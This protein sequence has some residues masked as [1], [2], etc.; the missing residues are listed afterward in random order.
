MDTHNQGDLVSDQISTMRKRS[1]LDTIKQGVNVSPDDTTFDNDI[2]MYLN[3]GFFL[4]SNLGV[5][6]SNQYTLESSKATWADYFQYIGRE[7]PAVSTYLTIHVRL[8][9]DPPSL[10]FVIDALKKQKDEYE[11]RLMVEVDP[12]ARKANR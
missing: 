11:W 2:Q 4:L 9:F 12:Q 8:L 3:A 5:G 1:I 6:P 7:L 10:S